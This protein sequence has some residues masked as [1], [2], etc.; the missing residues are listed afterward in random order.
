MRPREDEAM[1][2]FFQ[3]REA[4]YCLTYEHVPAIV[5]RSCFPKRFFHG[6]PPLHPASAAASCAGGGIKVLFYFMCTAAEGP[7]MDHPRRGASCAPL[8]A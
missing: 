7:S 4:V 3:V 8:G 6:D 5:T 2:P 1:L